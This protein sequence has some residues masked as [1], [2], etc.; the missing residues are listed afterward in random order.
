VT[1][2]VLP[3]PPTRT[4]AVTP[5]DEERIKAFELYLAAEAGGKRRS[6]R[7]ISQELGVHAV[8][9]RRWYET[10]RWQQ[11]VDQALRKNAKA[12][13]ARVDSLKQAVRNGLADGL[14]ELNSIVIGR[15][16][17]T[18]EKIE[19]TR[20]IAEIAVK[21][22]AITE[23]TEGKVGK[24]DQSFDFKDDL[25]EWPQAP[26]LD[27]TAEAPLLNPVEDSPSSPEAPPSDPPAPPA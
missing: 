18:R 11:K 8:T 9:V 7:S 1:R 12:T 6:F 17:K 22:G 2:Y 16:S 24:H 19:A 27:P 13:V 20:A 3:P 15:A 10:D 26:P 5:K 21:L 23:Q 25:A 14:A 4:P